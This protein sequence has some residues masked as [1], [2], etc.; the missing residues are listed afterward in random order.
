MSA[1]N[2]TAPPTGL[3]HLPPHDL[4]TFSRCPLEMELLHRRREAQRTST[5]AAPIGRV[6]AVLRQS[7]MFAP[8]SAHVRVVDG[9]LYLA[10]HDPLVYAAEG[11]EALPILFPPKRVPPHP[12]LPRPPP[13]PPP[14]TTAWCRR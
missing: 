7:P 12:P 4:V 9:R 8:S 14:P 13:P 2:L 10:P 3:L 1:A 11:A 6:S 5:T